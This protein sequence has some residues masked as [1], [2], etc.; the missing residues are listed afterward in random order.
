MTQESTPLASHIVLDLETL[1]TTPNAA[2]IAIGAVALD[3]RGHHMGEFHIAVNRESQP[4]RDIC[5]NTLNWWAQQPLE[6][7]AASLTATDS[8]NATVAMCRFSAWVLSLADTTMVK[9]WGNGS[10]FDCVILSTLYKQCHELGYPQPWSWWHDRDIR[11]VIDDF[12]Q[13]KQ[14]GEFEGIKHHA[15]HDARHEAKILAK[16]L[17]IRAAQAAPA[18][19]PAGRWIE[20]WYGSGGK[21]GY[22]GWSILDADSRALVA[23]LGREVN[24]QAVTAI[25]MAHNT[26]AIPAA[27]APVVM[28]EPVADERAAFETW[29]SFVGYNIDRWHNDPE[30]YAVNATEDAWIAWQAR[31]A[32]AA[33][34]AAAAHVDW[35]AA[36]NQIAIQVAKNCGTVPNLTHPHIYLGLQ[37]LF[38]A[39]P[40]APA[41]VAGPSLYFDFKQAT[42]L[43]QMF[44]EEPGEVVVT[45]GTGHSGPGM[46][47]AWVADMEG[48]IYLG[49]TDEDAEPAKAEPAAVAVPHAETAQVDHVDS[50]TTTREAYRRMF[51]AACEDLGLINEALDLDPNDGGAAPI[52]AAIKKLK[53]APPAAP[54]AQGDAPDA[55][56]LDFI[57]T[58]RVAL[59]PEFEGGWD[60]QVY[61][62]DEEPH[63]IAGGMSLRGAIDAARAQAKEGG[64]ARSAIK[65][66]LSM[67]V[68]AEAYQAALAEWEAAQ[69]AG[70]GE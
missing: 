20:R 54:A 1:S 29:A 65:P 55:E 67:H 26:A 53:A 70:K 10:S 2:V 56:R 25:V 63:V 33:T 62:E 37:E 42:E 22:E 45:M 57:G 7:Q 35:R 39:T 5:E 9:V 36:A 27:A 4:T 11:T 66:S 17:R 43:L 61:E 18:A 52:L 12:P 51:I 40:A 44:G 47:A 30:L 41:A 6:A 15:L 31:A 69:A 46:Y 59:I 68:S 3:A 60:V 16:A 50:D 23:Y 21:D 48:S 24:S 19:V 34:P 58:H 49:E 32:L 64:A 28:P 8:A 13:A 38:S 14:V